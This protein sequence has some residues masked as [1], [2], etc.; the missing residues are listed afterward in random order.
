MLQ[1]YF[2]LGGY[3]VVT[4]LRCQPYISHT[5]AQWETVTTLRQGLSSYGLR[6]CD[7]LHLRHRDIED[8][9]AEHPL[10]DPRVLIARFKNPVILFYL[11]TGIH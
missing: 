8:T 5:I 1:F 11:L 4:R 3:W 6:H 9:M 2:V 10:S 7:S